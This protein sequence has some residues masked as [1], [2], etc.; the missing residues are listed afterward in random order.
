MRVVALT[1]LMAVQLAAIDEKTSRVHRSFFCG[2]IIRD[3]TVEQKE[4]G[5]EKSLLNAQN[6]EHQHWMQCAIDHAVQNVKEGGGPFG[7]VVVKDGYLLSIGVNRVTDECD[8]SA[9]AEVMAIREACRI[10]GTHELKG[11]VLYTSCEP[12]PMCLGA[13]YWA[14]LDAVYYAAT[15]EGAAEVSFDDAFLYEEVSKTPQERKVP[16]VHVL[17]KDEKLPFVEWEKKIDK[18]CY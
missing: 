2:K 15:R 18:I 11:C 14:R 16:F 1:V 7:A 12:C 13:V 5:M 6:E 4:I 9:H 10:L 8:P 3:N 17:I